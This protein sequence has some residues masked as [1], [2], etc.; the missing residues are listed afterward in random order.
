M[1]TKVRL[2]MHAP[3]PNRKMVFP[4]GHS[5]FG[6]TEAPNAVIRTGI[7]PNPQMFANDRLSDCTAAST[8]NGAR[9]IYK[10]VTQSSSIDLTATVDDVIQF[11]SDCT[12][13]NPNDPKTDTGANIDHVMKTAMLRGIPTRTERLYPLTAEFNIQDQESIR[14]GLDMFG[15]LHLG[16][17]LALADQ[18]TSR[19]WDTT[20]P[21]DQTLA[22]WGWHD[23]NLWEYTGKND[24]DIVTL[25]TWGG[26]QKATWR[27]VRARAAIAAATAFHQLVTPA[28]KTVNGLLWDDFVSQNHNFLQQ[29][30]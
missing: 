2:G 17:G 23:L 13:Y 16:V 24:T 12:G 25:L 1:N 5:L 4:S 18:D 30:A 26:K 27:W 22:S 14:N 6:A 28:I 11:Y 29:A 21:G 9:G 20:T 7:E 19:V 10:L 8:Y 15:A 3:D